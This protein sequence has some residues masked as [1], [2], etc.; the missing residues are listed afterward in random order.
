[1]RHLRPIFT[2]PLHT[3][4]MVGTTTFAALI[5]STSVTHATAAYRL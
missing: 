3:L 2:V 1:M 4:S 5:A